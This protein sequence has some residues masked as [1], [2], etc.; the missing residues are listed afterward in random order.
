T[1]GTDPAPRPRGAPLPLGGAAEAR[2]YL[3]AVAGELPAR[4]GPRRGGPQGQAPPRGPPRAGRRRRRL[5]RPPPD[6]GRPPRGERE[7]ARDIVAGP[8]GRS[9]PWVACDKRAQRRCSGGREAGALRGWPATSALSGVVAGAARPERS[10]GGPRQARSA[11]SAR[12]G[13]L[14]LERVDALGQRVALGGER[15]ELALALRLRLDLRLEL[16]LVLVE[17]FELELETRHP[18]LRGKVADEHDV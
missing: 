8:R 17:L 5:P 1:L 12:G 11:A 4:E 13:E 2:P 9:A 16:R 14:A 18:P 6:L 15:R 3:P 7:A 10:V